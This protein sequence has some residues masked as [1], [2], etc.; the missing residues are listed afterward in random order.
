MKIQREIV[1]PGE[2]QSF[3]LFSPSLRDHFY[4]HYHPEYELVYVEATA[5]IRHVGLH[6]SSYVESD[7]VLIGPNIPHLNFDYGLKTEYH[8]VVVQLAADFLGNALVHTPELAGV[9][10][11]FARAAYGLS[12]GDAV[13]QRIGAELKAMF[14]MGHFEQ[15]VALLRI[16]YA[17][18]EEKDVVQLNEEHTGVKSMLNDKIRMSSVYEYIHRRYDKAPDVN[19]IAAQVHL[20][21][22]A[23]CRYFKRQ[24]RMTFTDFVNQYR[25]G[26][27]KTLL[28]QG[29]GVSEVAYDVGLESISYFNKLFRRH[30]GE[31]P[32]EFKKRYRDHFIG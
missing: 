27:A 15:L 18:A 24:T 1:T 13:K 4:W 11:L 30:A 28:L 7:L 21:T 16:F 3:R 23:F 32:S 10:R 9:E 26:Q 20:S 29:R 19:E 17:L 5:G 25:V 31:N 22:A 8:Q 6:V 2:G 14:S 12:F